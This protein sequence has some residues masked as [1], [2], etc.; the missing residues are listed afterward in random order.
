MKGR[1]HPGVPSSTQS[2]SASSGAP[3]NAAP[4]PEVPRCEWLPSAQESEQAQLLEQRVERTGL[5]RRACNLVLGRDDY[6][7]LLIEAP[8]VAASELREAVRWRI[9][10]LVDFPVEQAVV[11]AF[12]LPEDRSRGGKRM[13]YVAVARRELIQKRIAQIREANL[14]LRAI[15][16]PELAMRNLALQLCDTGRGV[17]LVKLGQG[18]GSL[19][20]VRGDDLHLARRFNLTYAGGLLEDLPAE[21]LVLELQRS[22]DY[23]E[24][25]MRQPPPAHIYLM[26]ENVSEDKLTDAL[27]EGLPVPVSLLEPQQGVVFA[28]SVEA[29]APTLC[30][31]AL[32]AALRTEGANR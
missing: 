6:N 7:L 30:L 31:D 9:R 23:F 24:R 13:A 28:D 2:P 16:I 11:D 20:I 32:G 25:Q 1:S 19:N 18:A 21:G 14:T 3:A 5:K 8:A 29:Y 22:L 10:D 17:A 27:R 26:G 12:L 4:L 15:D